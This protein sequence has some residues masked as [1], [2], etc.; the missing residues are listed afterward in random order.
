MYDV[1]KSIPKPKTWRPN[2]PPRKYPF[3]EMEVGDMFFVPN[4]AKNMMMN[5]ASEAGKTLGRRYST[6][7]CFMKLVKGFWKICD[8]TD[9]GAVQGIGVWRDK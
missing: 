2:Q 4:K 7:V 6:K 3:H 1:Q 8:V 9:A 5:R